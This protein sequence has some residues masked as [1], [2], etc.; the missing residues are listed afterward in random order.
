MK[1]KSVF[2]NNARIPI[3][4]TADGE[5][6]NP[7]LTISGIPK[8][9][10]TLLLINDDP[11][12]PRGTWLHWMIFNIP[13]KNETLEIKENSV[14]KDG[15]LGMTSSNQLEYS[16]PSPPSGTHRY[17]FKVFALD[18]SLDLKKGSSRSDIARAIQEHIIDKAELIGL[19]SR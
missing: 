3:K 15:I 1:I 4:Y 17:F 18:T 12:A 2:E 8:E 6:I 11:D 14:P 13:V 9:A 5:N 19:Y 7:P 16:G 10:K